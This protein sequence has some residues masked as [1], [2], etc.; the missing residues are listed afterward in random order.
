MMET[1]SVMKPMHVTMVKKILADGTECSKCEDATAQLKARDLW[2]RIDEIVWAREDDPASAGMQLS[3][4]YGVTRAPFFIVADG[5]GEAVYTSV[6]QLIRE[7]LG[8]AVSMTEQAGE[9]DPDDIG[10]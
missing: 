9:I 5:H 6:L 7:R 4:R 1:G 10:I 2:D 8:Q 3:V